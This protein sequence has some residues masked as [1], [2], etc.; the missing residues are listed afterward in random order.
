MTEIICP[1]CG[2]K[3]DA[4][5]LHSAPPVAEDV[6]RADVEIA[7]INADRDIQ[8]AKLA[9]KVAVDEELHEAELAAAHESGRADGIETGVE[10]VSPEPEPVPEPMPAPDPVVIVDDVPEVPAPPAAEE[11]RERKPKKTGLG[12]W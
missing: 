8:L 3:L 9:A 12:M 4:H 2:E 6:I 10:I 1:D 5:E 11:H 7:R